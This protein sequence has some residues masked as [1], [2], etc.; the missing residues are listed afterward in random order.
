LAEAFE[1]DV[2]WEID[3][4]GQGN[5]KQREPGER[6]HHSLGRGV[7]EAED[8]VDV[9]GGLRVRENGAGGRE[10]K[11]SDEHERPGREG[12]G[13][14]GAPVVAEARDHEDEHEWEP[15]VEKRKGAEVKGAFGVE[16]VIGHSKRAC[17]DEVRGEIN[18]PDGLNGNDADGGHAG[19]KRAFLPNGDQRQEE[20][21]IAEIEE[22]GGAVLM[23]VNGN[24]DGHE[25]GV[26][27]FEPEWEPRGMGRGRGAVFTALRN[28]ADRL[29]I[30]R[31]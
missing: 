19:E 20:R 11:V 14:E 30:H 15:A 26:G 17:A 1:D 6:G 28:F 24:E 7:V 27:D 2:S 25:G 5:E 16:H 29:H 13:F 22:I 10:E 12:P 3:R 18:A 4:S 9:D 8:V 31:Q 23:P 21:D